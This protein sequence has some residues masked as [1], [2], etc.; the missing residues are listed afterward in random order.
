MDL[1][2][3]A[4]EQ[5][6]AGLYATAAPAV[7]TAP[8]YPYGLRIN[9]TQEELEKLGFK[10]L[11]P[12]GTALRLEAVGC[13]TRSASEDPD[14]DGDID[15]LCV[16]VQITELGIEEEGESAGVGQE[17]GERAGRLYGKKE[18]KAA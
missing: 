10:D 18:A 2:S 15:Y 12:A 14:A 13:V 17:D 4:R 3:M 16:E 9:L 6:P 1:V 8:P 7:P 11:P 5:E